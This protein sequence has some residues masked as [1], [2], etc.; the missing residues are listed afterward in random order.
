[1]S[2]R[3]R[4]F[5]EAR[6]QDRCEY[7]RRYMEVIGDI[8]FEIEHIMPSSRGGST[9]ADNL[10]LSC[11]R[12]NSLK[13]AATEAVDPETGQRV[14]LF[15]PRLDQWSEHFQRSDDL[16]QILGIS[17]IGRATVARLQFNHEREQ[18]VREVQRDYLSEVYPLD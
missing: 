10:A 9:V 13:G 1:M 15:H 3:L 12:C 11:R 4:A 5:V 2:K 8:F 7:C 6:A 14:R 18:R 17:S 16:L